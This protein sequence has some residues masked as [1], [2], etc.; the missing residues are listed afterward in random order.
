MIPQVS[1]S[2]LWLSDHGTHSSGTNQRS[3]IPEHQLITK[4][5]H[6][7]FKELLPIL[8]HRAVLMTITIAGDDE[9]RVNVVP[10]KLKNDEN[11]ALTTPL[12]VTATAEQ[13]DAELGTTLVDFV[14]SHLQLKN[15]LKQAMADMDA[16]AKEAQAQVREKQKN[17]KKGTT[18]VIPAKPAVPA[19]TKFVAPEPPS[20]PRTAS[21]FDLLAPPTPP[22]APVSTAASTIESDE[23][24][25]LNEIEET[26]SAEDSLEDAA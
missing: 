10:K 17:A 16:A 5:F 14:G 4:E 20:Q 24:E 11:N 26:E 6:R 3:R 1:K 25:I 2:L 23:D 22:A 9:I 13:L 12:T 21:L 7:M 19:A 15:T 18:P 8:R